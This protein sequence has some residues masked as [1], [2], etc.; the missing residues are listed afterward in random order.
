MRPLDVPPHLLDLLHLPP[1]H[2]PAHTHPQVESRTVVAAGA[3]VPPGTTIPSGQVWAGS[4]AKFIRTL[5]E[6]EPVQGWVC[7]QQGWVC[8]WQGCGACRLL[9]SPSAPS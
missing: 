1:P 4:P 8:S 7:C 9:P 5:A 6:G 2:P 3:L